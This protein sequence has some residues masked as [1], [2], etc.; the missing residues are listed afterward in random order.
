[1]FTSQISEENGLLAKFTEQ[2]GVC[3]EKLESASDELKYKW[4]PLSGK[5][6]LTIQVS[7]IFL[8]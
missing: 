5:I 2:I 8:D 7:F 4:L 6:T 3:L 1:M